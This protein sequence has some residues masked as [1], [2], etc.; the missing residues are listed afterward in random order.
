MKTTEKKPRQVYNKEKTKARMID[1]V[2][3]ILTKEGF[4]NVRINRVAEIAGVDKKAIY[5][6]FGG[7]DGLV[8]EYLKQVDFWQIERQKLEGNNNKALPD[9]TKDFMFDLLKSDFQ[10]FFKSREMQK[11]ILWGISE[12]SKAIRALTDEREELGESVF[13]KADEIFKDTD[14][15]YRA[16]IAIL[17]S[18][19]YY[20]VLHVKSNGSTM[21]GIDMSSKEGKE[22]MFKA[23]EQYLSL[24]YKHADIPL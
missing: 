21:C 12:K 5:V 4:Q 7:L 9:I 3:K 16:S 8:K 19:I 14:V 2:S 23:M 24:I 15:D 17:V 20:T 6:Y 13:R 1:A 11:I 22:R 18:A 10:Y